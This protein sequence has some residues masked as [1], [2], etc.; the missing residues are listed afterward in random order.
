M[1]V[2]KIKF[3]RILSS[4]LIYE[5]LIQSNKYISFM[6]IIH[7]S[8]PLFLRH[9]ITFYV[10]YVPSWY[11]DICSFL[12]LISLY[13]CC[14]PQVALGSNAIVSLNFVSSFNLFFFSFDFFLSQPYYESF[15]FG[16]FSYF[17]FLWPFTKFVVPILYRFWLFFISKVVAMYFRK[18]KVWSKIH[19][20]PNIQ[21]DF[22]FLF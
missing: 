18:G 9:F 14:K 19:P 22:W 20:V 16:S 17:Q 5:V 13:E 2:Y 21:K 7:Y 12:T 11:Y 6:P 10:V 8:L 3:S 1:E 15:I 4:H